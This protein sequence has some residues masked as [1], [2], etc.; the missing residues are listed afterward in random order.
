MP[1]LLKLWG[2]GPRKFLFV[3]GDFH[4][5]VQALLGEPAVS[6]SRNSPTKPSTP[7]ARSDNDLG[8]IATVCH[9]RFYSLSLPYPYSASGQLLHRRPRRN[10][11]LE[12]IVCAAADS[13]PPS[14]K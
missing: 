14:E 13:R 5:H 10:R 3:P 12:L 1:I 4:D 11:Q 9:C 6:K 8:S 2:T 7:T